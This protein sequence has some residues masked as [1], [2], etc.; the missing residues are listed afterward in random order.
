MYDT[1][2]ALEKQGQGYPLASFFPEQYDH[3]GVV[4]GAYLRCKSAVLF[5][6]IE[7]RV[8][9][10]EHMRITLKQLIRSPPVYNPVQRTYKG[11]N[12]EIVSNF[13]GLFAG[14]QGRGGGAGSAGSRSPMYPNM[15]PPT[16]S[17]VNK[18][19]HY[20]EELRRHRSYSEDGSVGGHM[21]P[22]SAHSP[23]S[24]GNRSPSIYSGN[25]SPLSHTSGNL[26]PYAYGGM[27]GNI[28]PY[29]GGNISP[30]PYGPGGNISPNP[31]SM[32]GNMSPYAQYAGFHPT[33]GAAT[34]AYDAYAHTTRYGKRVHPPLLSDQAVMCRFAN[35]HL[36]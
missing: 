31:Y 8:G 35:Y 27:A 19:L 13:Q 20:N 33:L 21:S 30:N 12:T 4:Y 36:A 29:S 18:A 32:G 1:V 6:L 26:S 22:F 5:Q 3:F 7:N 23:Y 15:T 10:K 11:A 9:G 34:P 17:M 16:P 24:I 28:S 25:L 2:I 14:P